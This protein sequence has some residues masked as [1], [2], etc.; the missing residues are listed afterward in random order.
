MKARLL[1]HILNDTKYSVSNDTDKIC[2]GSSLC[3]DLISINKKTLKLRYA[4]NQNGDI[5]GDTYDRNDEL[6]FIWDKLQELIDSGEINAIITEDDVL[7]NPLPVFTYSQGELIST[8]TDEYGWPNTT[9]SGEMM[10]NNNWFKTKREAIE[11]GIKEEAYC[12]ESFKEQVRQKKKEFRER[13]LRLLET[14]QNLRNLYDMLAET[15]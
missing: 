11:Y 10:Y 15:D 3:H 6:L 14:E 9:I 13:K 7:E 4:L 5:R 8:F 2:V 1:K 12:I